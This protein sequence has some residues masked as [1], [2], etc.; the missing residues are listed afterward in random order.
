MRF[1]STVA[2]SFAFF[3][4]GA[5]VG[6]V[7]RT[8]VEKPQVRLRAVSQNPTGGWADFVIVEEGDLLF[9][10][11]IGPGADVA[12]STLEEQVDEVLKK[13]AEKLAEVGSDLRNLVRL[14][15]YVADEKRIVEVET[16]LREAL[17]TG[18][19]PALVSIG[20]A[21]PWPE[22]AVAIDAVAAVPQGIVAPDGPDS[23]AAI[24]PRGPA[25]FISGRAAP[26][27][28]STATVE[29]LRQLDADLERIGLHWRDVVQMKVFLQPIRSMETVR[30]IAGEFLPPDARPAL[31]FA[32][33][34][35]TPHPL[36]IELIASAASAQDSPEGEFI[37]YYD[38]NG[39]FSRIVRANSGDFIFT[40]L[41]RG[42]PQTSVAT[43][44]KQQFSMLER[45]LETAGSDRSHLLKATY[46]VVDPAAEGSYNA[47]RPDVFSI[48]RAPAA[49]RAHVRAV[50]SHGESSALDLI[51]IRV[52]Q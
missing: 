22:A 17:P 24:L 26:G 31:V 52:E 23:R 9:T 13:V 7:H 3:L 10:S 44:V 37:K 14:H 11:L 15:V 5:S 43:Q 35:E 36:E 46:Y 38:S 8:E 19:N 21:L 32:E 45:L 51:A 4:L 20:S 47:V 6:C 18:A 40:G 12:G 1:L 34:V 16:I 49:S 27:G 25:A 33:W 30:E 50:G 41:L 48:D 2:I 39:K 42:D 28:L 29:T